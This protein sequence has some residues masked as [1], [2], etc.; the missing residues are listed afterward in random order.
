[1]TFF[2]KVWK[3]SFEKEWVEPILLF[4]QKI[5]YNDRTSFDVI[6]FMEVILFKLLIFINFLNGGIFLI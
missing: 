1:M 3:S 2:K 6:V 4:F 5:T